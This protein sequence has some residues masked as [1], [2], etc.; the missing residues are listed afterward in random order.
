MIGLIDKSELKRAFAAPIR[1]PFRT[2]STV[3]RAPNTRIFGTTAR[4]AA[5]VAS[6]SF[7]A[8]AT[9]AASSTTIAWPKVTVRVSTTRTSIRPRTSSAPAHAAW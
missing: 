5:S 7:V 6:R 1:P 3:S 8:V 2:L 4:A 9:L